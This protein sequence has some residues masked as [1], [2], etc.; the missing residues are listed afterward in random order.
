VLLLWKKIFPKELTHNTHENAHWRETVPLLRMWTKLLPNERQKT[1][2]EEATLWRGD[3]I[4]VL[5]YGRQ[6]ET[7]N[8]K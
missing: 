5:Q 6:S 3:L 2:P 4:S 7:L 1:P 8:K